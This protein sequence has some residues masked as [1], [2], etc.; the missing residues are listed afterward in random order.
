MTQR[1]ERLIRTKPGWLLRI[2]GAKE[3]EDV[4]YRA[5]PHAREQYTLGFREQMHSSLGSGTLWFPF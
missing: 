3:G 2:P 5:D 1:Q 4:I